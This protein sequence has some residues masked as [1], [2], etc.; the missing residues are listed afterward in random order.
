M[1]DLSPRLRSYVDGTDEEFRKRTSE[2]EGIARS[3]D[4]E[5]KWAQVSNVLTMLER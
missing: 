1:T 3:K 5:G 4:E 2:S